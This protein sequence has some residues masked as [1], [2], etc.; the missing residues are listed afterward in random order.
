MIRE[1]LK[2]EY[3][4]S[5]NIEKDNHVRFMRAYHAEQKKTSALEYN[6]DRETKQLRSELREASK[7]V[8]LTSIMS[9]CFAEMA[10]G[11]SY[12]ENKGY[13]DSEMFV[14]AEE[15]LKQEQELE[16]LHRMTQRITSEHETM[17]NAELM[18]GAGSI[19]A[20]MRKVQN[21]MEKERS[22]SPV[23]RRKHG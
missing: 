6:M 3:Q 9:S 7:M 19:P 4:A 10:M 5:L 23:S 18:K 2:K 14:H 12:V 16:E 17:V 20:A 15:K 11:R 22:T 1:E 21:K 8:Q 13:H